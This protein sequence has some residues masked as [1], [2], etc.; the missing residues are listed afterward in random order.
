MRE[1]VFRGKREDTGKWV[2]G[3]LREIFTDKGYRFVICSVT[4]VEETTVLSETVG[5]Y[6]GIEDDNGVKIF[7]G[8]V[9]RILDDNEFDIMDS[10]P[11][12]FWDGCFMAN[13]SNDYEYLDSYDYEVIGNIHD[14]PELLKEGL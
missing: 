4:D 11:V 7:E 12:V 8:D 10:A 5:Q 1:I 9:V 6:T 3:Y 14:N 2:Y 13:F